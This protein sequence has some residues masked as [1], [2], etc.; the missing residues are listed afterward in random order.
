MLLSYSTWHEKSNRQGDWRR[1]FHFCSVRIHPQ[2]RP[3]SLPQK[4]GS[5]PYCPSFCLVLFFLASFFFSS[6][7]NASAPLPWPPITPRWCS[8]NALSA[9]S[10]RRLELPVAVN[11]PYGS[12]L[13]A[14]RLIDDFGF[15]IASWAR[16]DS[17][18]SLTGRFCELLE[19]GV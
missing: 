19:L 12:A 14:K 13:E 18:V 4:Y 10:P 6:F 15:L 9:S 3:P 11:R 8:F 16:S 7:L 17:S 2:N 1:R 5:L